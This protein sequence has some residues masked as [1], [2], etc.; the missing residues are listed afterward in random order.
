MITSLRVQQYLKPYKLESNNMLEFNEIITGTFTIFAI[1][2]F[3]NE[4]TNITT[5]DLIVYLAGMSI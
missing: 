4:D 2:I 3:N 1:I 5:I